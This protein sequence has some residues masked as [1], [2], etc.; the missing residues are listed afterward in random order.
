M[1]KMEIVYVVLG[2]L[3]GLF[4][5]LVPVFKMLAEKTATKVDDKI[6]EIA[7]GIVAW[8]EENFEYKDGKNKKARAV[9]ALGIALAKKG[10]KT[11]EKALDKAVENAVT[12]IEK[13]KLIKEKLSESKENE[14]VE[15]EMGK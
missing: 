6:L 9:S 1:T 10:I 3:T 14:K 15:G 5:G 4:M 13:D 7:I 2:T 12:I 11:S 8:Y